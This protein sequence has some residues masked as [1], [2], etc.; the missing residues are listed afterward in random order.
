MNYNFNL[1]PDQT[2]YAA[3]KEFIAQLQ[4]AIT[5]KLNNGSLLKFALQYGFTLENAYKAVQGAIDSNELDV[6]IIDDDVLHIT[7]RSHFKKEL[8]EEQK[9]EFDDVV[10]QEIKR[11]EEEYRR[12]ND[13][14]KPEKVAEEVKQTNNQEVKSNNS[15]VLPRPRMRMT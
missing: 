2:S 7:H 12:V 1:K 11:L 3:K 14:S 15:K 10:N 9:A 8:T 5:D 6:N 13:T 4:S